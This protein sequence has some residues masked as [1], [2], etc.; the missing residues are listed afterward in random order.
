MST[1]TQIAAERTMTGYVPLIE[2]ARFLGRPVRIA[3]LERRSRH[4]EDTKSMEVQHNAH[5]Q[6]LGGLPPGSYVCDLRLAEDGGDVYRQVVSAWRG[7]G[8]HKLLRRILADLSKYDVVL[9]HRMDRFGRN[10]E[11]ILVALREMRE[12]G[13]RLYC[14]GQNLDTADPTQQLSTHLFAMLAQQSSD[15]SS[16][17]IRENKALAKERG[18]WRGGAITYGFRKAMTTSADGKRVPVLDAHGYKTLELDPAEVAHLRAAIDKIVD[19]GWSVAAVVRWLNEQQVPSPRGSRRLPDGSVEPIA[20]TVTGLKRI[21]LNPMLQ[22]F[23]VVG[24]GKERFRILE[25]DGRRHRP[26]PP[27]VTDDRWH[28]LQTCLAGPRGGRRPATEALLAGLVVCRAHRVDAEPCGRRMY[29]PGVVTSNSASYACRTSNN[30]A[31]A[32]P[33]RCAG[34][35]ISARWLHRLVELTVLGIA[36]DPRWQEA[37]RE[38]YGRAR[39]AAS[40]DATDVGAL[41]AELQRQMSDLRQEMRAARSAALRADIGRDVKAL[42]AQIAELEQLREVPATV[43]EVDVDFVDRWEAM[44]QSERR[45]LIGDLVERIE[46]APATGRGRGFDP[47]RVRLHL[48]HVGVLHVTEPIDLTAAAAR[49]CRECG[50]SFPTPAAL[51]VHRRHRHG[52]V[53]STSRRPAQQV[54]VYTCPE[55]GC[56]RRT[57]SAG[58]LKRHVATAHGRPGTQ[59]CA[60]GCPKVFGSSLDL[61]AHVRQVHERVAEAAPVACP[62]CGRLLR[63]EH[64]LRVHQGRAHRAA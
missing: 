28:R 48:R 62:D 10:L 59:V 55:S 64:G 45:A 56:D 24:V 40:A 8:K 27:V 11:A 58:G 43:A 63:G 47:S 14:V 6:Y 34:N 18:G 53:G 15:L 12:A 13:V 25:V 44:P 26:H 4:D 22:G 21:L 3:L 37:L 30:L 19:L 42:D 29:G 35:A 32:D 17:R 1:F 52:V 5:R 7:D 31:E 60:Y 51:G 9:V 41:L 39:A 2:L 49:A 57:T 20:W 54:T 36:A 23:D 38:A 61:A 33:R 46:I 16:A 50:S